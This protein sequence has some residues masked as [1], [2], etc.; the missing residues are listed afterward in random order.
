MPA[1]IVVHLVSSVVHRSLSDAIFAG[2]DLHGLEQKR[3]LLRRGI[4]PV[5]ERAWRGARVWV[6]EGNPVHCGQMYRFTAIRH[7]LTSRSCQAMGRK[8]LGIPAHA[9]FRKAAGNSMYFE[10][11]IILM[12]DDALPILTS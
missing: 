12:P 7:P 5:F 2:P 4:H 1:S 6:T 8:S 9:S 10:C 11:C 3:A